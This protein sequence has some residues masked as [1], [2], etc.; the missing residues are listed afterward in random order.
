MQL[1]NVKLS[2]RDWLLAVTVT[3]A[4]VYSTE[5]IVKCQLPFG[6]GFPEA[7]GRAVTLKVDLPLLS[8]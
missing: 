1:L 7:A 2:T 8:G 4:E 6:Q 3:V 5:V